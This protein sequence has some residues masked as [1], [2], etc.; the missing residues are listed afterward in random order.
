[1]GEDP[2]NVTINNLIAVIP[3]W[4]PIYEFTFDMRINFLPYYDGRFIGAQGQ[5]MRFTTEDIHVNTLTSESMAPIIYLGIYRLIICVHNK[6]KM[7][8]NGK[9]LTGNNCLGDY[10]LIQRR[11]NVIKRWREDENYIGININNTKNC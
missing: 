7:D 5:V 6:N 9:D 10:T 3:S 4:G 11:N 2:V 8:P 1:M